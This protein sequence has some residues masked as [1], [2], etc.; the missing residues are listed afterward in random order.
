MNG[1]ISIFLGE[2]FD[3]RAQK[4]INMTVK[5]KAEYLYN[6]CYYALTYNG[7]EANMRKAA[8]AGAM[9]IT[10][11]I[12]NEWNAESGRTA[13]QRFWADVYDYLLNK[14]YE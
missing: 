1:I 10:R 14:S 5:E 4:T 13:K 12:Q 7:N 9:R 11:E 3:L 8:C 2:Y 6:L